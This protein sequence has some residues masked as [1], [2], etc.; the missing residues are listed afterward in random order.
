MITLVLGLF[1]SLCFGSLLVA[2][3]THFI[4]KNNM[5]D[6]KFLGFVLSTMSF[7]G[8]AL[9]LI[10]KFLIHHDIG[11]KDAFGFSKSN[12]GFSLGLGFLAIIISFRLTQWLGNLSMEVLLWLSQRLHSE[13]IHP[14]PQEVVIQLQAAMP[15]SYTLIY[16]VFAIL[17][18]PVAEEML[19][20]GDRKSVV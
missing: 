20:R 16:G 10:A 8:V 18:A 14:Q 9:L 6:R 11:W 13:V 15:L 7:Q 12:W 2:A 17:L 4:P 5:V 1:V 3:L 19:F